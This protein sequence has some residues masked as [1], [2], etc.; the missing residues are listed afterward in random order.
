MSSLI[1]KYLAYHMCYICQVNRV[2]TFQY[3]RYAVLGG[4]ITS[5][6]FLGIP[7]Y[8]ELIDEVGDCKKEPDLRIALFSII[9]SRQKSNIGVR[10]KT[11]VCYPV[12][13]DQR[14]GAQTILQVY[15]ELRIRKP[16]LSSFRLVS[17]LLNIVLPSQRTSENCPSYNP[18]EFDF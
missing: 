10:I 7:R 17:N 5:S 8:F 15:L 11:I 3:L 18:C 4:H 9:E 6:V 16:L 13:M 1:Q 12:I 14:M 2:F